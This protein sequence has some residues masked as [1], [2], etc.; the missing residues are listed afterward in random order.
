MGDDVGVGLEHGRECCHL[1]AGREVDGVGDQALG[2][3][4]LAGV[5]QE[6]DPLD[7]RQLRDAGGLAPPAIAPVE[8]FLGRRGVDDLPWSGR[9]RPVLLQVEGRECGPILALEDV[10]RNDV[11]ADIVFVGEHVEEEARRRNLELDQRR[12]RIYDRRRFQHLLDVLSPFDLLAELVERVQ[13]IGHV[14]GRERLAVAP[15][16]PGAGLDGK[17]LVVVAVRVALRQP[18]GL[19]VGKGAIER[20]RLVDD[21]A[22]E[23]RVRA[24]HVGAPELVLGMLSL[25][26]AADGH[27]GP[28]ARHVLDFAGRYRGRHVEK[29][30]RKRQRAGKRAHLTIRIRDGWPRGHGFGFPSLTAFFWRLK[31]AVH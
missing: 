26:A 31:C 22:A 7:S 2:E 21:V 1:Q 15:V 17:F 27:Q 29:P 3:L 5:G 11:Q 23:L 24:D 13:R 6:H 30:G 18:K 12:V 9:D 8:H 16:D 25:A 20:E 14:L 28:I 19:L 10:L 4:L